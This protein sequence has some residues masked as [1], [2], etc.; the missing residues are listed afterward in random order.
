MIL[1][2]TYTV[3]HG[4][5]VYFFALFHISYYEKQGQPQ[6]DKK[7]C[8]MLRFFPEA[9]TE[10]R[11]RSER[12]I[13]FYSNTK[14]LFLGDDGGFITELGKKTV[15]T[16]QREIAECF[17]N[18]CSHSVYSK[19]NEI[20]NG[21]VTIKGGSRAGICG[22]AITDNGRITNIRDLTSINIRVAREIL[23]DVF[24][25]VLLCGAPCS[26]KTTALRDLAR[27]LSYSKK[28]SLIDCRG[29][30]AAVYG[31]VAQND[32]GLCDIL[33]GYSK[34]DGFDH[35]VRCMSPDIIICDE[36]GSP[37]DVNSVLKAAE[38]GVSV[39]AAAHCR[40]RRELMLRP[41][42]KRLVLS[43]CFGK[44]VFL[45]TGERV[46]QIEGSVSADELV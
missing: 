20:I 2:I 26:G 27:V 7:R 8:S 40:D 22:T 17:N 37:D 3:F 4:K 12:P 46:G 32:V 36:L 6:S 33:D 19:Q 25:G 29:E 38:S 1:I 15:N 45:S 34:R 13:V 16:S 39:I 43:R 14:R 35:A 11:L 23:G 41:E 18:I 44:I 5:A 10:I 24:G 21:F 31:G 28:I 30:L 42:L 9:L